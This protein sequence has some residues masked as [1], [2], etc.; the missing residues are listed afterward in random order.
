M[1]R[2]IA[3]W[4]GLLALMLLPFVCYSQAV[5]ESL[6]GPEGGYVNSMAVSPD[7]SLYAI[8]G[9]ESVY[10]TADHGDNWT[11][12]PLV[13]KYPYRIFIH[14][15]GTLLVQCS[16]QLVRSAN[17][18]ASWFAVT[19]TYFV[20]IVEAADG[21]LFGGTDTG[22]FTS[23]D[24]G[25]HWDPAGLAFLITAGMTVGPLGEIW[26]SGLD[27]S[28]GLGVIYKSG[29]LGE[30]WDLMYQTPYDNISSIATLP[31]GTFLASSYMFVLRSQDGGF[32]WD[33]VP[34]PD[35]ARLQALEDG[36]LFGTTWYN[37][38]LE[39]EDEGASWNCAGF[40]GEEVSVVQGDPDG[41]VYAGVNIKGVARKDAGAT[42]WEF[43]NHGIVA[44]VLQGLRADSF[45]NLYGM[46]GPDWL[47]FWNSGTSEWSLIPL[48]EV[49][50]SYLYT[51]PPNTVIVSSE[52]YMDISTDGGASWVPIDY[53]GASKMV[54][55]SNGRWLAA[56]QYWSGGDVKVGV[57]R[58]DDQ[59]N[60]WEDVNL[61]VEEGE[62]ITG[63][64]CT[65]QNTFLVAWSYWTPGTLRSTDGGETWEEI[66]AL[67]GI[68][69]PVFAEGQGV[70]YAFGQQCQTYE[71]QIFQ[72]L[73]DGATWT[74]VKE[75][76]FSFTE[77][78]VNSN[79]HLFGNNGEN[80]MKSSNGGKTWKLYG[81]SDFSG[82]Y[83][84]LMVLGSDD[85]LYVAYPGHGVWRTASPTTAVIEQP[86]R[87]LAVRLAPN[88]ASGVVT[89]D[90]GDQKLLEITI[91]RIDG[92]IM[93]RITSKTAESIQID[94]SG[95]NP[96]I[97]LVQLKTEAGVT[98]RKLVVN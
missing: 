61:P 72:S 52:N 51:A 25:A 18:G 47:F 87:H 41:W 97:Y 17:G 63:M 20:E 53:F 2:L 24:Q 64:L 57:F 36:R 90:A 67:E 76:G 43:A 23:V 58:S 38:L 14:S 54:F 27:C 34:N 3:H 95:W 9:S 79:G 1:K 86:T 92:R 44:S 59:G 31:S 80:I 10:R 33:S 12:I 5:W 45:G 66:E 8:V 55:A 71:Y 98:G 6:E 93:T 15:N 22:L 32:T 29:D 75:L 85:V 69:Y 84:P 49:Y 46:T 88:P 48:P 94:V 60:T 30:T 73:D 50:Y 81:T 70:I 28:S 21:T 35:I 42:D 68:R 13:F 62:T 4:A 74:F 83:G 65:Q 78:A 77:L 82:W 7:G 26:V 96:G 16:S 56:G 11:K 40:S 89:I 91:S 39:S 37:G 19:S